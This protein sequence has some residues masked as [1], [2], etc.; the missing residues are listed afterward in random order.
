MTSLTNTGPFAKAG[1]MFRDS[2]AANAS[3]ADVV[4]TP[5]E[6]VAFEWR[7]TDGA[8]CQ[9]VHATGLTIPVWV[10]LTRSGNSFSGSYSTDGQTWRPIGSAETV[11]MASAAQAV[12]AVTAHNDGALAT[13][14]FADVSF[15]NGAA[16]AVAMAAAAS[17]TP[18]PAVATPSAA[19]AGPVATLA[20][21][22]MPKGVRGLPA[23]SSFATSPRPRV[24]PQRSKS[25]P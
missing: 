16:P 8:S 13:A 1:V 7:P 5:G 4:A 17:P 3:F 2:T 25:S 10:K 21:P 24:V 6:G 23:A 18:S 9:V 11:T 22:P 15:S 20:G 19:G 14:T 12:L